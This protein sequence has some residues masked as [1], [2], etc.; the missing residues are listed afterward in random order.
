MGRKR[1]TP[2]STDT[3]TT[4]SKDFRTNEWNFTSVS[5]RSLYRETYCARGSGILARRRHRLIITALSPS[6]NALINVIGPISDR[7]WLPPPVPLCLPSWPATPQE[8][9]RHDRNAGGSR[10]LS[11][12]R[13]DAA[14]EIADSDFRSQVRTCLN[15]ARKSIDPL[16]FESL[17]YH[18]YRYSVSL[19]APVLRS[20][21][22]STST[23]SATD[24]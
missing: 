14:P 7:R 1:P 5:T 23:T 9:T 6:L 13:L 15:A 2:W 3:S 10:N 11:V 19:V 24:S 8:I 17:A 4:R 21:I 20:V 22:L 12:S 18:R 16:G